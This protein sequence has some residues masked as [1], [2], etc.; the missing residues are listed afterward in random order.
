MLKK[1]GDDYKELNENKKLSRN[2]ISMTKDMETMNKN[3]LEMKNDIAEI[4]NALEVINS[5][6]NEAEDR[7]SEFE[8]KLDLKLSCGEEQVTPGEVPVK[9]HSQQLAS[10]G[11]EPSR[12]SVQTQPCCSRKWWS[13]GEGCSGPWLFWA[14]VGRHVSA[15]PWG[16]FA[17]EALRPA[18]SRRTCLTDVLWSASS[19]EKLA[20]APVPHTV[21][22]A[23]ATTQHAAYV[24]STALVEGEFKELSLGDFK[25]KYLVLFFHPLDFPFVCPPEITAFSD[26]A[27]EFHAVN[28]EVVAVPINSHFSHLTWSNTRR[29]RGGLGHVDIALL[30]DLTQQ[31]SRDH[32]ALREGPGVALTG[33]FII[34]PKGVTK[35]VSGND[36]PVGRSVEETLRLVKA[37]QLVEVHG[38]VCPASWTPDSPTI[39]PHLTASEEYFEKAKQ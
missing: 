35:H 1:L 24:K 22:H 28:W 5:R 9:K 30:S 12:K 19:G 18:A 8:Y 27:D 2:Y 23:P 17:S 10:Y 3:Q 21:P 32:G 31:I 7:I 34:D 6:L 11:S 20:L 36:L 33:L 38:E 39:K 14:M 15:I 13:Q 4:K 37:S 29:K 25:G 26:K 16:T